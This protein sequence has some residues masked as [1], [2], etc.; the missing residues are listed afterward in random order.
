MTIMKYI[1]L[2]RP[3]K[4]LKTTFVKIVSF[5]TTRPQRKCTGAATHPHRPVVAV[6]PRVGSCPLSVRASTRPLLPSVPGPVASLYR[7][8]AAVR[9]RRT[10]TASTFAAF[11]LLLRACCNQTPTCDQAQTFSI[12]DVQWTYWHV[13]NQ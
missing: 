3:W 8:T 7:A 4:T 13:L 6:R 9:C 11:P 5:V 10:R 12:R 1:V 2:V